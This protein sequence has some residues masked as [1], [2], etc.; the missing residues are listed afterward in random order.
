MRAALVYLISYD[1]ADP[2]RLRRVERAI[3][4]VGVRVHNSLFSCELTSIE[5]EGLQRRVAR[6]INVAADSVHYTPWCER[7]RRMSKHLGTS[8]DPPQVNAWI[9]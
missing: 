4:A 1:I 6:L 7:D 5:L 2:K 3:S 8:S 9:V